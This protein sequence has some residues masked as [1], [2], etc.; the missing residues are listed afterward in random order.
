MYYKVLVFLS[1][2]SWL[3]A[4]WLSVPVQSIACKDS[5]PKWH[6]M[7]QVGHTHSL[8]CAAA[9]FLRVSTNHSILVLHLSYYTT[10]GYFSVLA[11]NYRCTSELLFR[12][13][14]SLS[15]FVAGVLV[16]Q[17]RSV[18][19]SVGCFQWRLFVCVFVNTIT[20]E[21]VNIG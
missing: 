16:T 13:E 20:S 9:N 15:I 21:R 19:K 4:V 14:R 2:L 17:R 1:V 12:R 7:C 11:S 8:T 3:L 18:T 6:I 10:L 5:S